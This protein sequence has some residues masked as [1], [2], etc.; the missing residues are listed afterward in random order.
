LSLTP[1]VPTHSEFGWFANGVVFCRIEE[2]SKK[3]S[4]SRKRVSSLRNGLLDLHN[5]C[6][7]AA[8]LSWQQQAKRRLGQWPTHELLI[9]PLV[10]D[11]A[12]GIHWYHAIG[13]H[14]YH[15]IGIHW[16]HAIGIQS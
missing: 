1:P 11:H 16:Y 8:S 10:S 13:I 9:T 12:I 6:T 7:N 2:R 5:K 14:W 4:K 3:G 15:A